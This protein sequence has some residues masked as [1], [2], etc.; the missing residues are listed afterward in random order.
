MACALLT[1]MVSTV[2]LR[3]EVV[4]RRVGIITPKIYGTLHGEHFLSYGVHQLY[5]DDR[6]LSSLLSTAFDHPYLF[7]RINI[8]SQ[9]RELTTASNPTRM[10]PKK[11]CIRGPKAMQCISYKSAPVLCHT[12]CS[13]PAPTWSKLTP[14]H[15]LSQRRQA[16]IQL[17]SHWSRT[18]SSPMALKRAFPLSTTV[19]A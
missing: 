14:L 5:L 15:W 8:H 6:N 16:F 12:R 4:L 9:S 2:W 17:H 18:R 10:Y 3:L 11:F 19:K 7:L 13:S 1:W